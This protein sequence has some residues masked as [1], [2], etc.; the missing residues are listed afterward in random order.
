MQG[1]RSVLVK[2]EKG[3]IKCKFSISGV[4]SLVC[5]GKISCQQA[6]DER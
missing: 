5:G 3:P 2:I 6:D 1:Q 4:L